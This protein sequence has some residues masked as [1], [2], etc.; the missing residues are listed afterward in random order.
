[1]RKDT[2]VGMMCSRAGQGTDKH[3]RRS[4][5]QPGG[6]WWLEGKL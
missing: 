5:Q 1:M 2:V 3:D 6:G 4:P